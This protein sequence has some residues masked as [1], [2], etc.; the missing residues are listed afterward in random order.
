MEN[1]DSTVHANPEK[2]IACHP[3]RHIRLASSLIGFSRK[4][5][6]SFVHPQ[7]RFANRFFS[8]VSGK[9]SL[10]CFPLEAIWC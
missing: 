2:S 7:T 6:Y 4:I 8:E 10:K 9:M 1:P 3:R 5:Y